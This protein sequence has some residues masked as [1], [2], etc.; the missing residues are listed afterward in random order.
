MTFCLCGSKT[1]FVKFV[2]NVL[3]IYKFFFIGLYKN[4]ART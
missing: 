1:Y 2:I 4:F 3:I